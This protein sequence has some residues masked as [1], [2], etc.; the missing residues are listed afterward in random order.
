MSYQQT[1]TYYVY[2]MASASRVLYV[3]VTNHLVRRVWE[4]KKERIRGFSAR[5]RTKQLVCFEV[6]G[7]IRA[8]IAREKQ[9]KSWRREKKTALVESLNSRW[10]DLSGT[11]R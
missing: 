1:N 7:N 11:L 3:G 4:H 5:Y 2:T 6:F 9:I 8:A 10:E